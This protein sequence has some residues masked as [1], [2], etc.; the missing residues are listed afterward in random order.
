MTSHKSIFSLFI[1]VFCYWL[2]AMGQED[3]RLRNASF[4]D[5]PRCCHPPNG[6]YACGGTDLATPDIQPGEFKVNLPAYNGL[7]YVGMVTRDNDTWESISQ[8][9]RTPLERGNCYTFSLKI[10]HSKELL[11]QSRVTDQPAKYDRPVKVRVWGGNGF[12]DRSELLDETPL[13]SNAD[14]KQ[15]NL[16]FEPK[17]NFTFIIIEAFYKTPTLVPYN[18]NVLVDDASLIE[19]IPC[20]EEEEPSIVD[21]ELP[22]RDENALVNV[23]PRQDDQTKPP[24]PNPRPNP[25]SNP[26]QTDPRDQTPDEYT[27]TSNILKLDQKK[28]KEGEVI[29]IEKLYFKADSSNVNVSSFPVLNEIYVFLKKNPGIV[30]EVG[31]HTNNRCEDTFCN[32]LSEKRALAVAKYL[33]SKGIRENRLK[34]RGYGKRSPLATNATRTG[35]KKNQRVEI[36][37]L[38]VDG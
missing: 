8:R 1:A 31:G 25:P 3:V 5:S 17:K 11:S 7:T 18:G 24:R 38:S 16:R 12:C 14:W 35:R 6:W 27:A 20:N 26:Q 30:I 36:K 10:A 4:E 19:L 15:Y 34:Y 22:P 33:K 29:R 37:I 32:Q 2:P 23:S 9:L 21:V 28:L 13:I